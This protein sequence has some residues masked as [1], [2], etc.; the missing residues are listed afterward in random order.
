MTHLIG[1]GSRIG[2]SGGSPQHG[3]PWRGRGAAERFGCQ[4]APPSYAQGGAG[5]EP[6][7]R[8]AAAKGPPAWGGGGGA[9]GGRRRGGLGGCAGAAGGASCRSRGHGANRGHFGSAGWEPRLGDWSPGSWAWGGEWGAWGGLGGCGTP[10]V[11]VPGVLCRPAG[12]FGEG[13]GFCAPK[14]PPSHSAPG[15]DG[16]TGEGPPKP[17]DAAPKFPLERGA[18]PS[19]RAGVPQKR[20]RGGGIHPKTPA[21]PASAALM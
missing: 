14:A 8:P 6:P 4:Q 21:P 12:G 18:G 9:R 10:P 20:T 5:S 15:K 19:G 11:G 13:G 3:V 1:G 16:G 2:G 17:L 7:P